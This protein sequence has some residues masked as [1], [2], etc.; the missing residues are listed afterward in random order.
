MIQRVG[1]GYDLHRLVAGRRLILGGV[2]VPY[3]KGLLGHSDAD[4]VLHAVIDALL[5]AAGMEDIGTIFPDTD[6]QWKN[7]DSAALLKLALNRVRSA[8]FQV[9]N[10]DIT[11]LA[12]KPK[13]MDY[14]PLIR[15]RLAELMGLDPLALCIKAKTNEGLDAIGR[16]EAIGCYAVVSLLRS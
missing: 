14:K 5:G 13:L 16:G 9:N 6:P 12:E 11:L 2:E 15:K 10:L 4:V 7:A 1:M 8:G 3:E